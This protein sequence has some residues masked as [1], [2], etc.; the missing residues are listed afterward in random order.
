MIFICRSD[1]PAIL[2]SKREQI[3]LRELVA[4]FSDYDRKINTFNFDKSIYSNKAVKEALIA[5]QH[6]KCCFCEAKITHISYGDVEH[7]RPKAGY[8]QDSSDSLHKPG[9]YWLAYAW[10]NLLLSCTRCNQQ[11]K[12]NLFPLLQPEKRARSH[13][14]DI[15]AEQPLLINPALANPQDHIGFRSEIPYAIDGN[16]FGKTTITV[17]RLD[18]EELNEVRRTKLAEI[19]LLFDLI[20]LANNQSDNSELQKLAKQANQQLKQSV[21]PTAEYSA[22]V[23]ACIGNA[24]FD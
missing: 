7:Y 9:Y 23:S 11:F 18:R 10:D 19:I 2:R 6:G 13:H 5:M 4:S 21:L 16:V 20:K 1:E 17:L 8:K 15:A 22:M 12:K 3:E 24:F 14:E